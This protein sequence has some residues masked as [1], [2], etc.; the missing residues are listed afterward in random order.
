MHSARTAV[1]TSASLILARLSTLPEPYWAAITTLVVMQSTLGASWNVSWRRMIG[2]ALGAGVG[3]VMA[4]YLEPNVVLFGLAIFLLG[5]LCGILRLDAS[6]YRFAG[7]AL[8]IVTLINH[9]KIPAYLIAFHRF[10]EVGIGIIAALV[11]SALWPAR[12]PAT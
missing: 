7:M 11:L 10:A 9:G 4:T 8:A 2:T 5:I 3:G 1:A 12:D 6:A